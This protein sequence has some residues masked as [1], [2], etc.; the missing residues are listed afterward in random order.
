MKNNEPIGEVDPMPRILVVDDDAALR[1]LLVHALE[2][3]GYSVLSAE[4]GDE[5]EA[6]FQGVYIDLVVTDLVM[7]Q[8]DGLE[9]IMMVKHLRPDTKI[10][11]MSGGGLH[12]KS[13]YLSAARAFGADETL[14]K[15]FRLREFL[16]VV[17]GL[18]QADSSKLEVGDSGAFRPKIVDGTA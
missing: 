4:N 10:V 3:A 6:H 14:T 12:L 2:H 8:R 18:L 1:K 15:P 11:A 7:P 17:S 5:A 9:T 16:N 13:N